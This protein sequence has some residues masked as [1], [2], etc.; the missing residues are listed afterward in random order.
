MAPQQNVLKELQNV[1]MSVSTVCSEVMLSENALNFE[2]MLSISACFHVY[3]FLC[4][5]FSLVQ[6]LLPRQTQCHGRSRF[7]FVYT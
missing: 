5:S 1:F 7:V 6:G 2:F 4:G 3:I